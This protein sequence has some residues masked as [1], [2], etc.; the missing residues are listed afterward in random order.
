M[1]VDRGQV[2]RR[3]KAITAWAAG[4]AAALTTAFAV[5]AARGNNAARSTATPATARV[6]SPQQADTFPQQPSGDSAAQG[7]SPPAAS[8]G[9]P[10]GISGGS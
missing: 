8:S 1:G 2:R 6:R 10:A 3:V 4:G 5:G 7:F 9:P